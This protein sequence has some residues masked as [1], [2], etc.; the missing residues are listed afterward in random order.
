MFFLFID[1]GDIWKA[2]FVFKNIRHWKT[3][4][5]AIAYFYNA[6][7]WII[8]LFFMLFLLFYVYSS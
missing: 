2:F 8:F 5:A 7:K 3:R 4:A 6:K 1:S